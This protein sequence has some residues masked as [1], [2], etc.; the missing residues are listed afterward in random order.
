M[1][2]TKDQRPVVLIVEDEPLLRL[3]AVDIFAESGFEVLE[4]SSGDEA[5]AML[6]SAPTIDAVFTDIEMPGKTDGLA[7]ARYCRA[8]CSCR[9]VILTSG[10]VQPFSD[11]VPNGVKFLSKPYDPDGATQLMWAMV[12]QSS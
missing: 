2:R 7:L 6:N 10:R 3:L 11:D 12:G 1:E 8:T 9:A 4:A 5:L